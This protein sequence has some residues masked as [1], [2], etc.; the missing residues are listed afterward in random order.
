MVALISRVATQNKVADVALK[1]GV[2]AS[3][4]NSA[5]VVVEMAGAAAH[6]YDQS[7]LGKIQRSIEDF[8]TRFALWYH[9][10]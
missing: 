10:I 2:K 5:P 8:C 7:L 6:A 4:Q 3:F 9:H 1:E